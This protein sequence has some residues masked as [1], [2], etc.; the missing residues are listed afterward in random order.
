MNNC[1]L[2]LIVLSASASASAWGALALVT[3]LLTV[4]RG[5]R[6]PGR[7]SGGA[8]LGPVLSCPDSDRDGRAYITEHAVLAGGST[9]ALGRHVRESD[10]D[11]LGRHG[12]DLPETPTGSAPRWPLRQGK[13]SVLV[14][15]ETDAVTAR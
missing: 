15:G 1:A 10:V 2:V 5:H 12:H 9:E 6:S 14:S 4:R 13:V 8:V 3:T 7:P 11:V